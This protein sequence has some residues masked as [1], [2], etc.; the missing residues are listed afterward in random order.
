MLL[1]FKSCM[2]L[3]VESGRANRLSYVPENSENRYAHINFQRYEKFNVI[4]KQLYLWL[5]TRYSRS[6]QF[7]SHYKTFQGMLLN[8]IHEVCHSSKLIIFEKL[9]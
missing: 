2:G 8:I 5:D 9:I 7:G 1:F 3:T 4:P 6:S